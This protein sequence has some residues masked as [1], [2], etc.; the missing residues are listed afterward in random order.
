MSVLHLTHLTTGATLKPPR[1]YLA[2]NGPQQN[3]AL[4]ARYALSILHKPEEL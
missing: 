3:D 2:T 4:F 1:A